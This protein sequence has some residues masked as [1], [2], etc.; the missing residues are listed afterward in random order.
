MPLARR[1]PA[2]LGA[3]LAAPLACDAPAEDA[4][5]AAWLQT[6]LVLD[7]QVFLEADPDLAAGKFAKMALSRHDFFRGTVAHYARDS[8]QAGSPGYWPTDHLPPAAA[9]IPLIGDPHLENVGTYRLADGR[10]VVDF[11]D[12]DAATYGPYHLDLR[13][14]AVAL[15]VAGL[16]FEEAAPAFDEAARARLVRAALSAY[17]DELRRLS[18]ARLAPPPLFADDPALGPVLTD[19]VEKAAEDGLAREELG[20]YT[21]VDG[22]RRGLALGESEPPRRWSAGPYEQVVHEDALAPIDD[23]EAWLIDQ[24]LKTYP[25][26]LHDPAA[27]PAAALALKG[28]A[29]RLGAGVA[30]YPVRRY[31][32]LVEGPTPAL[33]DDWL[34]ELKQIYDPLQ[35]PGLVQAPA[36]PFADNGER[37]L[38]MHRALQCRP[39]V[40]PLFGVGS[41]GDLHFRVRERTKFQRGLDLA[42][43]A[44]R[45]ADGRFTAADVEALAAQVG[46]LLARAH[47]RTRTLNGAPT[48]PALAAAIAD[49]DGLIAETEAFAAAYAEI[50]ADDHRRLNELMADVGPSLGYARR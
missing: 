19:L 14:M 13:R 21:V 18:A 17:V 29:R 40:D 8:A 39:D 7:N 36:R 38:F 11:N 26:T 2:L 31:Y 34:L 42:R 43:I 6:T 20:D 49:A 27:A 5:R 22:G 1:S 47:A 33:E 23:D 28:A 9:D 41:A 3:A 12:L 30:S 37:L 10:L 45:L 4:D 25:S 16:A 50:V 48:L 46:V 15:R 24:V 32:A 44:A 35:V